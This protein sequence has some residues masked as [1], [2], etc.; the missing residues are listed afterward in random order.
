M[1]GLL[2]LFANI[3]IVS[4][5]LLVPA[6]WLP[7]LPLTKSVATGGAVFFL[8]CAITHLALAFHWDHGAGWLIANHVVQAISVMVFVLGFSRLLRN[9][10]KKA[11]PPGVDTEE[12]R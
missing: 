4:G 6:L 8:T 7:F 10:H 11:A 5:Y 2:N 1:G 12:A 3:V 9:A